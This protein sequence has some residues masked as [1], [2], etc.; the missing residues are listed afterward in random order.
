MIAALKG[1]KLGGYRGL[2]NYLAGSAAFLATKV[3]GRTLNE[4]SK[5]FFW[6]ASRETTG[7][8]WLK[9]LSQFS[10][11]ITAGAEKAVSDAA[12]IERLELQIDGIGTASETK[13]VR[14]E[15]QIREGIG[16]SAKGPFESAHKM[17][18]KL[19]GFNSGNKETPG[20][21]D[22]WWII[23]DTPTAIEGATTRQARS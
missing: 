5:Q 2:W 20:A 7:I 8:T 14:V 21:P 22:P 19:M 9:G 12:I 13:L 16:Q 18:G 17:L 11:P 15:K 4:V 1:E 10:K 6:A 23:D 3:N